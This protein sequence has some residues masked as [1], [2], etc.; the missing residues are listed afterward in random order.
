[1]SLKR[2][3]LLPAAFAAI[4]STQAN[5]G[6]EGCLEVFGSGTALN[7]VLDTIYTPASCV[8]GALGTATTI[9]ADDPADVAAELI[10]NLDY[11][12]DDLNNDGTAVVQDTTVALTDD[13]LAMVY[14]PTT[15]IPSG[16]VITMELLGN[17][18][19]ATFNATQIFLVRDASLA[20]AGTMGADD[21]LEIVATSDGQVDG[22]T[23]VRFISAGE[24]KAGTRLLLTAANANSTTFTSPGISLVQ[25]ACVVPGSSEG[26]VDLQVTSAISGTVSIQGAVTDGDDSIL[27]FSTQFALLQDE[28]PFTFGHDEAVN[29]VVDSTDG[30]NARA[31]F[32]A[33]NTLGFSDEVQTTLA[34]NHV[35][36]IDLFSEFDYAVVAN[37]THDVEFFFDTV[38]GTSP[39]NVSMDVLDNVLG[40]GL[41]A[42]QGG[43][44]LIGPQTVASTRIADL[45]DLTQGGLS[46][47]ISVQLNATGGV[48]DFGY[49]AQ[50]NYTIEFN[51]AALRDHC[52]QTAAMFEVDINGA[53][54]KVPYV[55]DNGS[56]SQFVR[57]TNE[58]DAQA[59]VFVDV[60]DENGNEVEAVELD[61]IVANGSGLYVAS[62]ISAA[63][64]A[65]SPGT[66]QTDRLFMTFTVTAPAN[67]VFATSVQKIGNGAERVIP[68]F[69]ADNTWSQ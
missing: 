15:D 32:V 56:G 4:A 8:P 29:A 18:V 53:V 55:T 44:A 40:L 34:S 36:A 68:V 7:T 1:M 61:P 17:G 57:I 24:I 3:V 49:T 13:S 69:D 28:T 58:S 52:L 64:K 38:S 50:A 51:S 37:N 12:F 11:G 35:T 5:A 26:N 47:A 23:S 31:V 39:A 59:R 42:L 25:T 19:M 2:I 30:N 33:N 16:S 66:L 67:T 14:T 46:Q 43:S 45:D 41:S 9:G 62:Q 20:D 60:V 22:E 48:M 65:A 27:D 6:V 10:R 21:S 54:I 63:A